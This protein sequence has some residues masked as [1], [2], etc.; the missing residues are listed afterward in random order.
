MADEISYNI[1]FKGMRELLNKLENATRAAVITKSLKQSAL[2]ITGWIKE[3]RLTGRPGLNVQTGRLR[4]SIAASEVQKSG[5]TYLERIGTNV[6]YARIHEYGGIIYPG[7][8]G[9]L[10]WKDRATNK[11]IFTKRPVVIPARPFMRPALED[12]GN[13]R[14]IL[15]NLLDNIQEALEKS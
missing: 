8:K 1:E 11:W 15:Q 7:A 3:R 14:M 5:N 9:F 13:Q 10:A 2:S 12:A 4:S 6:I